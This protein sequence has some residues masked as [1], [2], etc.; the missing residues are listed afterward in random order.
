MNPLLNPFITIPFLKNY[1]ADPERLNRLST[2]QL[3]RYRDRA[4]RKI[5]SYTS[6]VP[7]YQEKYKAAGVHPQ[8]IRTIRDIAKH[9]FISKQDLRDNFPDNIIPRTYKKEN[10]HVVCTGGSTGKPVSIYTDFQTILRAIGPQLA[11]MRYYKMNLRKIRM[12]HIG[13]FNRYRID[14]VV[15]NN[16][17]P[18]MRRF[19]SLNNSLNID[20]NTPVKDIMDRLNEFQPELI[21]SYPALFQHLA[22][23][24]KKGLGDRVRPRLLQVGGDILDEYTRRYVEDAF[25]CP[26][27]NIYPAVEAQ[28]N[29]AF[30]CYE[31]NWHIH[32]DFFHLEAMDEHGEILAPGERG[33][34]VITRLWGRGTPIVR[35]TGIDDWVTLSDNEHCSCGLRSVI[36][37]K[38][39]EGR[40]KANIVLPSG[41]VFPPGAFCFIEPV[42]HDLNTFKIKQ[43]QVIQKKIDEIEI[44]LAIDEDLR[45][46]GPSF[47]QIASRIKDIYQQKTGPEVTITVREVSEIKGDPASGKPAPIVV[48]HVSR[49]EGFKQLDK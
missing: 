10:A 3:D 42:L 16:F 29:I 23:L 17:L 35:Y 1:L 19:Y 9:P 41:K 45:T 33:H 37:K 25:G 38:P 15:Q 24:K 40:M 14:S 2:R 20:V 49:E 43:Y 34:L 46:T 6:T 32:A 27:R 12:A 11:E 4:L 8:D 31:G 7:L 26:L 13:N 48:S 22:F 47:D 39:V 28:A 36:F 18:Q 30:E 21:L 44:L 5:I